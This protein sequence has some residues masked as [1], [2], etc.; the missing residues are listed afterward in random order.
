MMSRKKY[1]RIFKNIQI[2]F[3]NYIRYINGMLVQYYELSKKELEG[4]DIGP[5]K[6]F[7][8]TRENID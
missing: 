4:D 2:Y 8:G 3:N 5:S 1:I 7:L 6:F